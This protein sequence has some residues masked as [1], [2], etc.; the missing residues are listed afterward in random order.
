MIEEAHGLEP[1]G[2]FRDQ[3]SKLT[4][5]AV[6]ARSGLRALVREALFPAGIEIV[7]HVHEIE[8]FPG[9]EIH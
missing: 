3:M 4:R 2:F 5:I 8:Q 7:P 9:H 6:Q 1:V